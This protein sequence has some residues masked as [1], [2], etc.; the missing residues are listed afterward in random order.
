MK[1]T[2]KK[3]VTLLELVVV[4]IIIGIGAALMVPNIGAWLPNYRLRSAARDITSTMRSAQMKAVSLNTE[5]RVSFDMAANEYLVQIKTTLNDWI[6]TWTDA[7]AQIPPLQQKLPQG[8]TMAAV[9][10]PDE[11]GKK[12]AEFNP[13]STSASGSMTLR[14]SKN[15]QKTITLTSA[16]GRVKLE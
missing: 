12:N 3:G 5:H 10:F 4:F 8:V 16:T 6:P 7:R 11:D 9:T 15:F 14:N 13:N 1:M 2:N